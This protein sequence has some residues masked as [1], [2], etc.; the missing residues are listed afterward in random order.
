VR[1]NALTMVEDGRG[2]G[3]GGGRG[4]KRG[5]EVKRKS[6]SLSSPNEAH[7]CLAQTLT[8]G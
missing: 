8:C 3:D 1:E 2:D 5:R 6:V 7:P 4:S